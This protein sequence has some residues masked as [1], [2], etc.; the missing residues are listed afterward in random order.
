MNY[1][2]FFIIVFLTTFLLKT[3]K[4]YAHKIN[5]NE[6]NS[7]IKNFIQNNPEVIENALNKIKTSRKSEK[8]KNNLV[9]LSKIPNPKLSRK[10]SDVT[11]YEFFD[12]N[13][14]YCKLVMQ[15]LF[16]VYKNDKKVDIVFVEFPIL[17]KSSLTAALTALA[18]KNQNKYFEL[19]SS[20]MKHKG[21]IDE[22]VILSFAEELNINIEKLKKQIADKTL[23]DIINKNRQIANELNI[24]GT[25]AFIIGNKIYPGAMSEDEIIEALKIERRNK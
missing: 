21:K 23:M 8:L 13:C 1:I 25:P 12:Y 17:S 16:N 14:G 3:E 10:N 22:N 11:I 6:I 24:Q 15:S 18:S 2:Y 4:L 20:L 5:K 9:Y 19:H 7:I